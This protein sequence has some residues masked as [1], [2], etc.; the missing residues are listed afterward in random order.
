MDN[1]VRQARLARFGGADEA[2]PQ[3]ATGFTSR[4]SASRTVKSREE[5]S[6]PQQRTQPA[7]DGD[8]QVPAAERQPEAVD[9]APIIQDGV[10]NGRAA[11]SKRH[12]EAEAI[13]ATKTRRQ[14]AVEEANKPAKRVKVEGISSAIGTLDQAKAAKHKA[15]GGMAKATKQSFFEGGLPSVNKKD[16]PTKKKS[17]IHSLRRRLP[18]ARKKKTGVHGF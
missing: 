5:S 4:R 7:I 11:R 12:Q 15:L 16:K 14:L 9:D 13:K 10:L 18:M 2:S 6:S 17:G 8:G 3:V 1:K